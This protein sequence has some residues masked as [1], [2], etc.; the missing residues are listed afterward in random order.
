MQS[1]L[2]RGEVEL[3]VQ[4]MDQ[5]LELP[6][7]LLQGGA[8]GQVEVESEEADHSG[9]VIYEKGNRMRVKPGVKGG[10]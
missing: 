10:E 4:T 7:L 2:R 6:A 5:R 1:H 8:A 3:A 9:I